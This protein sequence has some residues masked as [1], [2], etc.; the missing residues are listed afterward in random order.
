MFNA[1]KLA[2]IRC[3]KCGDILPCTL[4][5]E[6]PEYDH[7]VYTGKITEIATNDRSCFLK[8][9]QGHSLERLKIIDFVSNYPYQAP[10]RED[11]LKATNGEEAFLIKRSRSDVKEPMKYELINGRLVVK[12][13]PEVKVQK[14][15]IRKVMKQEKN[16][17]KINDFEIDSFI[18]A[19]QSSATDNKEM[20]SEED[21]RPSDDHP[22]VSWA[23]LNKG[24]INK[25]V[26]ECAKFTI[27]CEKFFFLTDFIKKHNCLDDV[28]A[29][30]MEKT[31]S[32]LNEEK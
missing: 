25:L 31:F 12:P 14:E 22:M 29:V 20:F 32:I 23:K 6:S 17:L 18:V 8:A 5:D 2:I 7:D 13:L 24:L 15:N 3:K 28:L 26:M 11:Y 21:I 4:F 27:G 10:I 1:Y 16:G 9:H 30:R 19:H